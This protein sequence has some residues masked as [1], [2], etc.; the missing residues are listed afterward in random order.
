MLPPVSILYFSFFGIFE[1]TKIIEN[2]K[3][4][5]INLFIIN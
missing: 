1:S 2:K 5:I 4:L 3:N